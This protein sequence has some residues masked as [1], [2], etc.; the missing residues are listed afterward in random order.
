[1]TTAPKPTTRN[2]SLTSVFVLVLLATFANLNGSTFAYDE[3]DIAAESE[4]CLSATSGPVCVLKTFIGCAGLIHCSLISERKNFE[5]IDTSQL[6]EEEARVFAAPWAL[7]LDYV[8][9]IFPGTTDLK[10]IGLFEASDSRYRH[11]GNLPD[12]LRGDYELRYTSLDMEGVSYKESLFL[13]RNDDGQWQM[14]SYANWP[15]STASTT[16]L[17][18][19]TD[20]RINSGWCSLYA[21]DVASW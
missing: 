2:F 7:P 8:Y 4:F 10:V 12:S 15:S 20:E 14:A 18:F 1:M 16:C 5:P 11:A 6:G 13:D 19:R 21:F 17:D 9:G 3:Q